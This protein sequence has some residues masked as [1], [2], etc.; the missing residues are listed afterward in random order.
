MTWLI[1]LANIYVF[2][3]QQ[4]LG[5]ETNRL[6]N[7]GYGL[8]PFRFFQLGFNGFQ[9]LISFVSHLFLHAGWMHLIGN[10]WALWLFGDNVEDRMG[11]LRF[12]GFYIAVGVIAGLVHVFSEPTLSIPTIGASGAIAGVMG[13]YFVMYP[14]ARI[15]TLVPLFFIPLFIEIPA[16]IYLGFWL[17][18]QVYSVFRNRQLGV[19]SNIAWL[20]HIGGFIA[21]MLFHRFFFR[22][23]RERYRY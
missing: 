20:A 5:S 18:S 7:S 8:V 23:Y 21:G 3:W 13:A 14:S 4:Q 10:I 2:I 22:P 12:L 9:D 16:L 19:V 6:I 15:V 17:I 1:I 11:S